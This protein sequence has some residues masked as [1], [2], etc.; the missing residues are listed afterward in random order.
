MIDDDGAEASSKRSPGRPVNPLTTLDPKRPIDIRVSTYGVLMGIKAALT[1]KHGRKFTHDD[2][3][4][5][6]VSL[7]KPPFDQSRNNNF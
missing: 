1:E 2:V 7:W 3:V 5:V 6:L 4:Q